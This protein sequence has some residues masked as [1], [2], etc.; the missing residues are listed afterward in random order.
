MR[1][2][3]PAEEHKRAAGKIENSKAVSAM[4]LAGR[5]YGVPTVS[6][7]MKTMRVEDCNSL[8]RLVGAWRFE[9]QASC[10]QG[11]RATR[12]RYAPT[13]LRFYCTVTCEYVDIGDPSHRAKAVSDCNRFRSA[14]PLNRGNFVLITPPQQDWRRKLAGLMSSRIRCA[15]CHRQMLYRCHDL[16]YSR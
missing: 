7:A 4:K 12:L 3:H 10:A 11:R 15:Q 13:F 2:V 5:S 9:L 8:R 1:C 6:T 14:A 16:M